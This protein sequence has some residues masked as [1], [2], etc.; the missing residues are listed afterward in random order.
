MTEMN[1]KL[2]SEGPKLPP[3]PKPSS[4]ALS[5]TERSSRN[6]AMFC[7]LAALI[8]I[9]LSIGTALILPLGF[10]GPLLV[11]LAKKNEYPAVDE[12]GMEATNF[13]ITMAGLQFV[14]LL[15]PFIGW[16]LLPFL[17]LI[18]IGI[19]ISAALKASHGEPYRYALSLR[20]LN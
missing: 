7:H 1:D 12:H 15:V 2:D 6:W 19:S 11:W 8:G 5:E 3:P 14:F 16:I 18:N 13:Q 17:V 20:L 4:E 10:I 9:G